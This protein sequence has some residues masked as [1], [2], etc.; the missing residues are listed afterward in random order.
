M[1]ERFGASLLA[2]VVLLFAAPASAAVLSDDDDS[3][4]M[5]TAATVDF[6]VLFSSGSINN[7]GDIEIGLYSIA[8]PN[9]RTVVFSSGISN[10]QTASVSAAS[11]ASNLG[12]VFG[13]FIA[14]IGTTFGGPL[15]YFSDSSI[16]PPQPFNNM[17]PGLDAMLFDDLGGG[18]FNV[19]MEDLFLPIIPGGPDF[20]LK[21]SGIAPVVAPPSVVPL[22]AGLLLMLTALGLGGMVTRRT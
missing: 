8:N 12:S 3:V 20:E 1:F 21:V 4:W 7:S 13:F 2:V 22:P 11:I 9:T 15:T 18:M 16:N 17:L 10:G 14:N 5:T 6:E 19:E